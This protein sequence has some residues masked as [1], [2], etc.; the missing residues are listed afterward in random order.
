MKKIL[1][2][3]LVLI[4]LSTGCSLPKTTKEAKALTP[5]EAKIRVTDFINNNLMQPGS[6]VSIKEVTEE[7]GMYK[8][9]VNITGGQEIISY[10]TKD[11]KKFFPQVMDIDEVASQKAQA[12]EADGES[13][14][15]NAE[16]PKQDKAAAELY[17]MA[18]CPYG[19]QAEEALLPVFELLKDKA[20]INIRYIASI[21]GDDISAVKSLHGPIEG[22]E[23]ARQL[24]VAKNY[25][26]ATLWKY[27]S[28]IN[29]NCYAIYRQGDDIYKKCWQAAAKTAKADVN[30]IDKCVTG[31]GAGLIKAEDEAATASGVSGSPTLIINGVKYNGSRTADGFKT[32]I[33]SGFTTPPAECSETL[34]ATAAAASGGC[35]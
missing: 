14:A 30:K 33:C 11:G 7:N 8:I 5:E 2:L 13:A 29:K 20:D 34:D 19:V 16:I 23:D 27:V 18:F 4:F 35:E 32:A 12:D 25:D 1:F 6:E 31:E 22:I 24:C 26:S 28:E 21:E 3:S 9:I 15:A 10:L 17:V